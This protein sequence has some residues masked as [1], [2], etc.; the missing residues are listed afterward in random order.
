MND[1]RYARLVEIHRVRKLS[2]AK[3]QSD[4]ITGYLQV[5]NRK[6]LALCKYRHEQVGE[7]GRA[8][9]GVPKTKLEGAEPGQAG[10]RPALEMAPTG[11]ISLS[12]PKD[13]AFP[14]VEWLKPLAGKRYAP[15]L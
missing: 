12:V 9:G 11:A 4:P 6:P 13:P 7:N 2:T 1:A 3:A 10:R 5:I 8:T 14:S 15:L